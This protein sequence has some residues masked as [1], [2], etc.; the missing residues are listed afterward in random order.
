MCNLNE[1]GSGVVERRWESRV[2][3]ETDEDKGE[4]EVFRTNVRGN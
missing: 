4:T 2:W 3:I 1:F